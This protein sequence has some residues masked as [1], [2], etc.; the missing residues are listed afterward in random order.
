[1][2]NAEFRKRVIRE[3]IDPDRSAYYT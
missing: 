2:Q 1:M 3:I